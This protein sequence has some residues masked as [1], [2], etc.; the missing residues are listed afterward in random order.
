MGNLAVFMPYME[1]C[2]P[3][4]LTS[5]LLKNS[6]RMQILYRTQCPLLNT[7]KPP[8]VA[9]FIRLSGHGTRSPRRPAKAPM[10]KTKEQMATLFQRTGTKQTKYKSTVQQIRRSCRDGLAARTS[11]KRS[12][13][14]GLPKT[15]PSLGGSFPASTLAL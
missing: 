15:V 2:K 9:F 5:I 13:G 14:L 1:L 12:L 4:Y 11:R 10:A 6:Q 8:T 3:H 7:V